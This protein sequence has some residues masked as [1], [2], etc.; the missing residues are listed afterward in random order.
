MIKYDIHMH[1]SFSTDSNEP[2]EN[3]ILS[4]ID[5]GLLG[6][7]FTEHMDYN[8]PEGFVSQEELDNSDG[9]PVFTFDTYKYFKKLDEMRQKYSDRIQILTGVEIGLK[10]DAIEKNSELSQN[11]NFDFIIGSTHLVDNIDIYNKC[12][13]ESYGEENGLK[14]YFEAYYNN[15]NDAKDIKF[16][17]L[18]HL[19]YAVRY[20][21]SGYNFYSYERFKDII[22]AILEYIIKNNIALEINTSGYRRDN[23][24]PNP[25]YDIILRYKQMGGEMIT[26]GADAHDISRVAANFD[27]AMKLAIKAGFEKYCI[28]H[29][30]K[31][32]FLDF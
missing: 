21:P 1:S 26:F 29:K 7:C 3:M 28:F 10:N 8:F 32:K 12:Y 30:H 13:W 24:M 18:G 11:P 31:V 27:D 16:D 5:K 4:A 15:L 2:M 25:H 23:F 6:I 22:D 20:S 9:L 19:D 17:T 14:S